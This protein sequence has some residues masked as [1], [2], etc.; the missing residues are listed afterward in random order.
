M[1]RPTLPGSVKSVRPYRTRLPADPDARA[2]VGA[3]A[4]RWGPGSVSAGPIERWSMDLSWRMRRP[5][6]GAR[7]STV[8]GQWSRSSPVLEVSAWM[9]GETV[10][11]ALDRVLENVP[12]PRSIT[13]DHGTEFQSRALEDWAPPRRIAASTSRACSAGRRGR[14]ASR[15]SCN[16]GHARRV[17]RPSWAGAAVRRCANSQPPGG[18]RGLSGSRS[19]RLPRSVA[20]LL[21]GCI[22]PDPRSVQAENPV[23]RRLSALY[24]GRTGEEGREGGRAENG[25]SVNCAFVRSILVRVFGN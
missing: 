11:E 15:D 7:V 1:Q 20:G 21:D 18:D 10:G 9:S 24:R 12:T 6:A 19:P 14:R 2:T 16:S 17:R 22:P 25:G 8:V 23:T 4:L 13:V 3:M 5:M